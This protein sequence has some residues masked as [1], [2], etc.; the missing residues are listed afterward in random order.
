VTPPTVTR[1]QVLAFRTRQHQLGA[2]RSTGDVALLDA[3]VQDTGPDGAAWALQIRGGDADPSATALAWTLR[4]APHAYRRSDLAAVAVATAPYSEADAAKR[5]FDASKPLKAAG[6][7]VLEALR[8]VAAHLR[9]LSAEP[10]VKGDASSALT[11]LLDEPYLRWCRPCAATHIYEQPFRLAALQAG[12]ELEAATSPPV[13]R[14]VAKMAPPNL[15]H[16]AGDADP[17]LDVIRTALRFFG[18]ATVKDVATYLDTTVAEVKAHWPDD[19]VEV[20]VADVSDARRFVLDEHLAD[21]RAEAPAAS[22]QVDLVGA[23]DPYL[24][25]RGR[26]TLVADPDRRKQLWP[27][28]GRPGAVLVDGE[29]VATWRPRTAGRKLTVRLDPWTDLSAAVRSAIDG[30]AERLAAFRGVPLAG[31]IDDA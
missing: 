18:P 30:Q 13:L 15:V 23:Y 3:G 25:L 14:R 24:Q 21:L 28:L 5:V 1:R 11:D 9:E 26:D 29:V 22:T 12:L 6:I 4:G 7:P 31:V 8:V 16:L 20:T 27:V 10:I 19:A 2:H 17:R